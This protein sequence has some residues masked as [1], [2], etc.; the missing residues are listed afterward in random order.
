MAEIYNLLKSVESNPYYNDW[1]ERVTQ[2]LDSYE[3]CMHMATNLQTRNVTG[4]I[5]DKSIISHKAILENQIALDNASYLTIIVSSDSKDR[6]PKIKQGV[7]FEQTN[8]KEGTV[9]IAA[10]MLQIKALMTHK[11]AETGLTADSLS[12]LMKELEERLNLTSL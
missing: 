11:S 6:Q 3:L 1:F 5:I 4:R 9:I 10:A 12:R 2:E 8:L 7:L